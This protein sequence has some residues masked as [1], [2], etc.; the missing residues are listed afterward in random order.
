MKL[1]NVLLAVVVIL[2]GLI[3]VK[4]PDLGKVSAGFDQLSQAIVNSNQGVIN[5]NQKLEAS[6][7]ELKKQLE[8]ISEKVLKK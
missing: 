3:Y 1:M 7:I 2:L 5:S 4:L 6:M 8:D